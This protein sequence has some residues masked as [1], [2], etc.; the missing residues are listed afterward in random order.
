M[1]VW[2]SLISVFLMALS[3][4]ISWAARLADRYPSHLLLNSICAAVAL[5]IL[6][7]AL[8][9]YPVCQSLVAGGLGEQSGPFLTSLLLFLPPS[10]GMGMVSPFAVRLATHSVTSV[11]KMP[12]RCMP[13]PR[14]GASPAPW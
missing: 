13:C 3:L 6:A 4:V 11:G 5:A 8:I 14:W 1:F 9:A 7:L 12:A 2:G 10:V